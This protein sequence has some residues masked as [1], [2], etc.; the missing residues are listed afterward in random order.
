MS[1]GQAAPNYS[2]CFVFE[3][4]TLY[5]CQAVEHKRRLPHKVR[6]FYGR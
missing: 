2:S 5:A 6:L 3:E 4:Y 1:G